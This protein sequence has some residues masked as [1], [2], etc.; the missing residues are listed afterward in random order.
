MGRNYNVK[1]SKKM[2]KF[3]NQLSESQKSNLA[4]VLEKFGDF[5]NEDNYIAETD[6]EM[7]LEKLKTNKWKF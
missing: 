4:E 3:F 5:S 2:L 1:I 7:F 6:A